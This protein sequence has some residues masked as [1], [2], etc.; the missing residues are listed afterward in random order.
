MPRTSNE[1]ALDRTLNGI[2]SRAAAEI[3][4]AV[5]QNIADEVNRLV[6]QG[7]VTSLGGRRGRPLGSGRKRRVILCPVP[8]CGKPGGGP[9]WGWFCANHKDLSAADKA[10]ARAATRARAA[11]G[12]AAAAKRGRRKK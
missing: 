1:S 10:K 9:K 3:V 6:G 7:G 11:N 12:V 8:G 2:V 4:H 5:R